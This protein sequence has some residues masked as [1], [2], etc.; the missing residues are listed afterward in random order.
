MK[1]KSNLSKA[2]ESVKNDFFDE[3]SLKIL[4]PIVN[5]V[6]TFFIFNMVFS[7]TEYG[8]ISPLT[9]ADILFSMYLGVI[10]YLLI[11]GICG[12]T[13]LSTIIDNSSIFLTE[14]L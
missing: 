11:L 2:K 1:E 7:L 4:I 3:K 12:R 13:L 9:L 10:T 14:N 6:F 5:M 8:K